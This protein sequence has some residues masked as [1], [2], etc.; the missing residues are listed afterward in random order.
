MINRLEIACSV[1]QM[2]IYATPVGFNRFG[3]LCCFREIIPDKSS[4]ASKCSVTSSLKFRFS[5]ASRVLMLEP[6]WGGLTL[7]HTF[8]WYRHESW[9]SKEKDNIIYFQPTGSQCRF[10]KI[11]V[12]WSYFMSALI[13][14]AVALLELEWQWYHMLILL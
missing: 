5:T 2:G 7:L 8:Q 13:S 10:W 3:S 14:Q 4:L 6:N 9:H 11:G 1:K 12:M